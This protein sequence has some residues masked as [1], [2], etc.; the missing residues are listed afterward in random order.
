MQNEAMIT[1]AG[2]A[3]VTYVTRA[4][5]LWLISWFKPSPRVEKG[6]AHLPGAVLISILA[7]ILITSDLK[8]LAAV[9]ITA[10][11]GFRTG[12]ILVT[13]VVGVATMWALRQVL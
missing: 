10:V 12:N 5:G 8:E 3:L 2:M 1:I 4:S 7:P 11:V 13:M 6:L 9:L